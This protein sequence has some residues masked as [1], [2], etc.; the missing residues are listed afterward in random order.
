[1]RSQSA[2]RVF[3]M[4]P[5]GTMPNSERPPEQRLSW[6]VE[7]LPYLEQDNLFARLDH[8]ASWD[9]QANRG[10]VGTFLKVLHCP[11][12]LLEEISPEDNR[13]TYI[14]PAGLGGDAATRPAGR[15][16]NG[17]FGYDRRANLRK[18]KDGLS[19]TLEVHVMELRRKLEAHGPRLI[20]TVR[21]K[22]YVLDTEGE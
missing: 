12:S 20:Q 13:T 6:M 7:L 3:S 16:G 18:I 5:A 8:Q 9:A 22:G 10:A 21:G 17:V 14:G 1:M 4:L 11:G 19:N 2:S 15:P